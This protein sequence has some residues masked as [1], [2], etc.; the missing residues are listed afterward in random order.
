VRHRDG[1]LE[2]LR[3]TT[4]ARADKR[5]KQVKCAHRQKHPIAQSV[6]NENPELDAAPTAV[7]PEAGAA[8]PAP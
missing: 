3:Y 7:Q 5:P 2:G 6:M 4:W 1:T 8:S